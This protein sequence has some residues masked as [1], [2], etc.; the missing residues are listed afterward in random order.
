MSKQNISGLEAYS[1][2]HDLS[3][4]VFDSSCFGYCVCS[5]ETFILNID[6]IT[7]SGTQLTIPSMIIEA[8]RTATD[9]GFNIT[10]TQDSGGKYPINTSLDIGEDNTFEVHLPTTLV[11]TPLLQDTFTNNLTKEIFTFATAG[12]VERLLL[13]ST[14]PGIS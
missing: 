8:N 2:N 10:G 7:F 13:Y 1:G 11:G 9:L 4:E 6:N 5:V 14:N 3:F 12:S